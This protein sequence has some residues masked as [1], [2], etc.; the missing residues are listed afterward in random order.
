MRDSW[1]EF[2]SEAPLSSSWGVR[3]DEV[4]WVRC[5]GQPA[6]WISA[7]FHSMN[8]PIEAAFSYQQFSNKHTKLLDLKALALHQIQVISSMLSLL[9]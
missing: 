1:Q 5:V 6:L 2:S 4:G 9:G 8:L 7:D 3:R